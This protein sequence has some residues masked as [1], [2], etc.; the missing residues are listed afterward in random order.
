MTWSPYSMETMNNSLHKLIS[1]LPG[2]YERK[3]RITSCSPRE[4]Q[5]HVYG[6]PAGFTDIYHPRCINNIYYDTPALTAYYENMNGVGTRIKTRIRWYGDPKQKVIT[7]TLEFKYKEGLVGKKLYY[8]LPAMPAKRLYTSPITA[9]ISN[10]D[11]PLLLN[12]ILHTLQP[13]LVN[14]YQ[15][16]YYQSAD[17]SFRITIDTDLQY[18][19]PCLHTMQ[20]HGMNESGITVVELKYDEVHD[21]DARHI[22]A[23]IPFPVTKNSKFISGMHL[24]YA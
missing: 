6:I 18:Y 13:V 5:I 12:E 23:N 7:P 10:I 15:R 4:I 20:I 14:N 9:L 21:A 17:R 2:R 8:H 24:V 11:I 1:K 3:Y 19:R 16:T 22:T